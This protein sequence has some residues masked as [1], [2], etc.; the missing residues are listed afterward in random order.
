MMI[1][2]L[3]R[4]HQ[5]S[6]RKCARWKT[7]STGS[8]T[9]IINAWENKPFNLRQNNDLRKESK[10]SPIVTNAWRRQQGAVYN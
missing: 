8:I 10:A 6:G 4:A 9:S 5:N 3:T 2:F 7:S 1:N